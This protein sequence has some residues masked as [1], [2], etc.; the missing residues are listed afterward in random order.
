MSTAHKNKNRNNIRL[1][2]CALT[3]TKRAPKVEVGTATTDA[4]MD[5]WLQGTAYSQSLSSKSKKKK[6]GPL[7]H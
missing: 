6:L 5:E 4:N 3:K 7:G 1:L 2:S